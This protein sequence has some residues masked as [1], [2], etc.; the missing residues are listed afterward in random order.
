MIS[1][2]DCIS[3]SVCHSGLSVCLPPLLYPRKLKHFP[4][5][6][7]FSYKHTSNFILFFPLLIVVFWAYYTTTHF[8]KACRNSW[9][10]RIERSHCRDQLFRYAFLKGIVYWLSCFLPRILLTGLLVETS[11]SVSSVTSFSR[12]TSSSSGWAASLKSLCHEN[13]TFGVHVFNIHHLSIP[14]TLFTK[15]TVFMKR[16]LSQKLTYRPFHKTLPRSN[17]SVNWMTVRFYETDC[18]KICQKSI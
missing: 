17:A 10:L 8:L 14:C 1:C 12:G 5:S 2:T 4:L 9:S 13:V 16:A 18:K 6:F 7:L 15:G 3:D 11:I